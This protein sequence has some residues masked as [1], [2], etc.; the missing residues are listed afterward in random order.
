MT[1]STLAGR[2][3]R[4]HPA[5]VE[6]RRQDGGFTLFN[7]ARRS[8]TELGE[9]DAFVWER[10]C[11]G[12]RDR[13]VV[14][15]LRRRF[16]MGADEASQAVTSLV[17]DMVGLEALHPV[18]PDTLTIHPL[19]TLERLVHCL[20]PHRPNAFPASSGPVDWE[21][22]LATA[23][24]HDLGGALYP[25]LK[26]VGAVD[27]LPIPARAIAVALH[28]SARL[29]AVGV[30]NQALEA[31]RCLNADGIDVLALKGTGALLDGELP[32]PQEHP[33]EQ[34][35]LLVPASRAGAA[36]DCLERIG[37]RTASAATPD[38]ACHHLPPLL[39][40]DH[41]IPIELQVEILP[42]GEARLL[43]AHEVW[44]AARM[45]AFGEV[46]LWLPSATHRI[47]HGIAHTTVVDG[48]YAGGVLPLRPLLELARQRVRC[49]GAAD[50]R[51]IIER[52]SE[53]GSLHC[54]Q[55]HL[56]AAY[57]LFG[58]DLPRGLD[59]PL[60]ARIRFHH[61][62]AVHGYRWAAALQRWMERLSGRTS[63]A[64]GRFPFGSRMPGGTLGS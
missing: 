32:F 22:V 18:D 34:I 39:R 48:C 35:N 50:W 30:R 15:L 16:S 29:A 64:T 14:R 4:P 42:R 51:F 13:R 53:T 43:A 33:V 2:C 7:A 3:Y 62:L 17:E 47:L 24:R 54:L 40:R 11:G 45:T 20:S 25:A 36:R 44:A 1:T 26:Q 56:Y 5:I 63:D 12:D 60:G 10:L 57:R 46:P 37:Y 49:R 31:I 58:M 55:T 52:T 6:R 27:A 23:V 41:E 19:D 8:H 61:C 21:A 9:I 59:I 38:H 28:R